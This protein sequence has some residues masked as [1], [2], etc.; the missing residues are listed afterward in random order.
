MLP[1]FICED[2]LRQKERLKTIIDNYIFME[3]LD[4]EIV[5]STVDPYEI[6][7]YL[8]KNPKPTGLYFFDVSLNCDLDGLDLASQV[9]LLDEA[10]KIVFITTHSELSVSIFKN[11]IEALD[12]IVKDNGYEFIQEK[13]VDCIKITQERL[14]MAQNSKE[15]FFKIKVGERMRLIPFREIILFK[16]SEIPNR[17]DLHLEN[18][19][20]QFR[21]TL[22]EIESHSS[23]FV[24]VHNETVVNKHNIRQIYMK[25]QEIEMNNNERCKFSVRGLKKLRKSI[26]TGEFIKL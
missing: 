1:I 13:I 23:L 16:A 5:L 21:G 7:E 2:D 14:L 9:R 25:E 17:I 18:R 15:Q 11:K 19:E 12:Y 3:D 20:F 26:D 4:M 6:L 10:G 22:K 24:R 8:K